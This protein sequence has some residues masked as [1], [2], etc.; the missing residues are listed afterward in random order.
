MNFKVVLEPSSEDSGF[1]ATIPTLPGCISEGDTVETAMA[2]IREAL[3]LH[4][5]PVDDEKA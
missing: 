5:E 1:T 4:L 3:Q 2:N